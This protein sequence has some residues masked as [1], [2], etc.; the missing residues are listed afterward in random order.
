M[1]TMCINDCHEP[2]CRGSC[3]DG[4]G[5]EDGQGQTGYGIVECEGGQANRDLNETEMTAKNMV[6][7]Q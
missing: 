6:W 4:G 3:G 2:T 5:R 1:M 7:L